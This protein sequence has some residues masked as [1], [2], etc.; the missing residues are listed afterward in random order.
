MGKILGGIFPAFFFQSTCRRENLPKN[1]AIYIL[2]NTFPSHFL[3]IYILTKLFPS[4]FT[5]L[6]NKSIVNFYKTHM[7]WRGCT[8]EEEYSKILSHELLFNEVMLTF[9]HAVYEEYGS[10]KD[11]EPWMRD[12]IIEWCRKKSYYKE[13]MDELDA[14][15]AESM[16]ETK[17][18]NMGNRVTNLEATFAHIKEMRA[19][20]GKDG[21]SSSKAGSSRKKKKIIG[22]FRLICSFGCRV[23]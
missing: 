1:Q 8:V 11:V 14:A 9:G 20:K 12:K 6:T 23:V 21:A 2:T 19:R 13:Y 3:P 16:L 15:E 18:D 5:H 17:L 22:L 7:T 4:H 10:F